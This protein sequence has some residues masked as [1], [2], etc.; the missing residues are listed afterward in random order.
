VKAQPTIGA[1]VVGECVCHGHP[2]RGAIDSF[3]STRE[4][5]RPVRYAY[6][7]GHVTGRLHRIPVGNLK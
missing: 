1:S 3:E 7:T 5:G 4:H 2:I 6:V